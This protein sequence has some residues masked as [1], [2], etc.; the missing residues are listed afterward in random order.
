[1]TSVAAWAPAASAASDARGVERRHGGHGR[2]QR[3]GGAGRPALERGG[4]RP[5]AE[6]LG[7]HERVARARAGVGQHAVRVRRRPSTA[8][9]Y[10]GS[11]SSIEW[12]P[13]TDAPAARHDVEAAAQDLAQDVAAEPLEREGDDVQRRERRAAHRVDV[14]ERVGRGDA[15]EVVGVVD[16]GGEEVDRLDEREVV[17]QPEDGRVVARGR[18]DE[19]PGSVAAGRSAHDRQ[20][21]GGR[22]ACTRSPP[23]ARARSAGRRRSRRHGPLLE[24]L[25]RRVGLLHGALG[26]RV[27]GLGLRRLVLRRPASGVGQL[28]LE[29]GEL[30]LGPL[31]GALEPAPAPSGG[32]STAR[33]RRPTAAGAGRGAA[34]AAGGVRG[35]A[36]DGRRARAPRPGGGRRPCAPRAAGR[37]RPSRR[38]SCAA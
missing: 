1:M 11:G 26:R 25:E 6:R 4:D 38:R 27:P 24:R 19:Q 2:G 16:D 36:A 23:R 3:L 22:A 37:T 10:F 14:G 32:S 15:P 8:R 5:H 28:L 7:Q 9:P 31:D 21:V 33:A 30:R 18:A 35:V 12:P 20:Q 13:T 34:G 17:A 29:R